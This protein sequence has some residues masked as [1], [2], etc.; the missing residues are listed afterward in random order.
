MYPKPVDFTFT[1]DL[2]RFV[3]FLFL[4]ALGGLLYSMIALYLSGAGWQRVILRSLDMVTIIVPPALPAA[5]TI[6]E[7]Q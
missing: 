7:Q 4:M 5:M 6:G 3:G 1:T 2:F